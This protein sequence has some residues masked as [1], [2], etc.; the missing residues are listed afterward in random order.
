MSYRPTREQLSDI[1]TK[2]I[3]LELLKKKLRRNM[4]VC[5]DNIKLKNKCFNLREFG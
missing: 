5:S 3:K 4:G 1:M 2:Q